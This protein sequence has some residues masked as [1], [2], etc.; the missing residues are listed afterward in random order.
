MK[1]GRRDASID[2][3]TQEKTKDLKPYKFNEELFDLLKG[4]DY[5]AL[6]RD[7]KKNGVKVELHILPD[8]TVICGH[9]RLRIAKEKDSGI[10]HL[11]CKTVYGLDTPEK[12][13]E[14]VILD[15]L[16]RRQLTSEKQAFLLDDLSK[17]YETGRGA[18]NGFRGNQ[19]ESG[20]KDDL[21]SLPKPLSP[22]KRALLLDKLSKRETEDVNEKTAKKVNVSAKT[23]QR[24]RSYVR[25]VKERPKE[26]KGKKV[27]VVLNKEKKRKKKEKQ[28]ELGK[29]IKITDKDIKLICKDFRDASEIKDN[30]IDLILTDPPYPYEYIDLWSGLSEFASRV[31]KPNGFCIAYSGHINLPEVMHR[32]GKHLSFYWICSLIHNGSTKLVTPRNIIAGWKPILIYQKELKKNENQIDDVITGTGREKEGHDW[33]QAEEEIKVF[34]EN[35]SNIGETILDPFMGSGT[36]LFMSKNLI[37]N[38]LV[39]K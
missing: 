35:F 34:I 38:L 4:N 16:L 29:K 6:K 7:I 8:K 9:Q 14:Y 31:L 22:E 23:V 27:N 20:K 28:V 39:L 10:N 37:E 33:Q 24:A 26:Y 19:Y 32:M 13:R 36:T 3:I 17:Q 5:E 30:S 12:V 18:L 25:A 21:S 1:A 15:N 2:I 11:R